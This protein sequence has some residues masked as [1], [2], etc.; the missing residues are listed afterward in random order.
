MDKKK[1]E[2]AFNNLSLTDRLNIK[3]VSF[4]IDTLGAFTAGLTEKQLAGFT[5]DL[6]RVLRTRNKDNK[7]PKTAGEIV[8]YEALVNTYYLFQKNKKNNIK[9]WSE[10]RRNLDA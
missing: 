2:L 7:P 8:A 4:A 3:N 10:K 5:E 6:V 1:C 9:E